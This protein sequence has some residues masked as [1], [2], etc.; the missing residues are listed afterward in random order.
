MVLSQENLLSNDIK[1]EVMNTLIQKLEEHYV[2][3]ELAKSMRCKLEDFGQTHNFYDLC[4]EQLFCEAIT[5]IMYNETKDKHLRLVLKNDAMGEDPEEQEE[6]EDEYEEGTWRNNFGFSKLEVLPG[7]IGYLKLNLF[8]LTKT[9][10]GAAVAAMN[11]LSNT[12]GLIL[13]LRENGGGD[14]DMVSFLMSY[15]VEESIHHTTFYNRSN[16][17]TIQFWTTDYVQGKKYLDKPLHILTSPRTFSA[18]ESFAYNFKVLKR[19]TIVGETTGGG[20]QPGRFHKIHSRFEAFIS[21]GRAINT[22]TEDNWEGKGVQPDVEVNHKEA[23]DVS[24]KEM[25]SQ[26]LETDGY[27]GDKFLRKEAQNILLKL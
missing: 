25:M 27:Q 19:A 10:G 23:F 12:S 26:L 4:D 3:P 8:D 9:G 5:K 16:N 18:A 13:D 21:H 20:A 22:E 7:N 11:F 14:P 15:F 24:Y 17:S 6:E 2:F 1:N